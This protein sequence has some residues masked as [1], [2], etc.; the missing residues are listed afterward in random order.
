M[1]AHRFPAAIVKLDAEFGNPVRELR[2]QPFETFEQ[3]QAGRDFGQ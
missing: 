2:G 1:L 3:T